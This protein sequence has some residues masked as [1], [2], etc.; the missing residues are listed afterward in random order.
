MLE[1]VNTGLDM[2]LGV[3]Y[4]STYNNINISNFVSANVIPP[5]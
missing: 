5:V 3:K 2:L 1:I 4:T